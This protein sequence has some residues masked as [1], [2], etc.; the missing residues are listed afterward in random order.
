MSK[1]ATSH[2]FG[3]GPGILPQ[4]V[5]EKAAQGV[6]NFNNSGLSILEISHRSTEFVEVIETARALVK[7][8]LNVPDGY[9]VLFLNGG[10]SLQFT[11]VPQ[12][13][14]KTKAAYIE[15]GVWAQKALK[16]AKLFGAVD[17]IASSSD[18]N[19]SYIPSDIMVPADADYVHL[20]SN[21]TIY[22][23]QY[24]SFPDSKIPM[25][26]DMSSDIFSR[27]VD[28]SK[29]DLIYAGAQ[30]NMGPAGT[31]CVIIKDE[32]LGK[33]KSGIP[34]IMN[35]KVHAE[36][37]SMFNTP[38]CF[39]VYTVML[40]MQWLK[41]I[42]GVNAIQKINEEK[43]ALLYAEIDRNTL[44]TGNVAVADRSLMNACFTAKTPEL[45]KAFLKFAE[46]NGIVGIKGHRL[47]GG[48]RASLYNALPLSS[49]QYLV[50]LM[51]DFE[52]SNS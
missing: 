12:C 16:E 19:F 22:G 49:V 13:F 34:T 8:L 29:F 44:F 35:Y 27:P 39:A 20:C 15:T 23:T 17:V 3:A 45:G 24:K 38:A 46:E 37:E 14:L 5:I 32:M 18:K 21:N 48:F 7:E 1:E 2:N 31:T 40:T 42:G 52:K 10:A 47:S 50:L 41:E 30:K 4:S 25:I 9:T 11:M 6:L 36:N 43:A 33:I 28:V 51:Q 26:C